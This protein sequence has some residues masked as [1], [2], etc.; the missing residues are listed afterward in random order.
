MNFVNGVPVEQL[1]IKQNKNGEYE[2]EFVEKFDIKK[3]TQ[4]EILHRLRKNGIKCF[5]SIREKYKIIILYLSN[6]DD[7]WK[8]ID[9]LN[10]HN[11][12]YDIDYE[13][14]LITVDIK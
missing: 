8:I 2:I 3:A 4:M 6:I 13:Q 12:S 9:C 14:N 1:K 11:T 5:P 10:I 7:V